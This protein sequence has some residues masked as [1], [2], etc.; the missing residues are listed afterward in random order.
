M[1]CV[2]GQDT[3]L[4][5]TLHGSSN[6]QVYKQVQANGYG[7]LNK[8][9]GMGVTRQDIHVTS[10][11]G[12]VAS[13]IIM[14]MSWCGNQDWLV[15]WATCLSP[16]GRHSITLTCQSLTKNLAVTLSKGYGLGYMKVKVYVSFLSLGGRMERAI[17]NHKGIVSLK[18]HL[19]NGLC[20]FHWTTNLTSST[21]SILLCNFVILAT[22]E[23]KMNVEN[24]AI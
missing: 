6:T 9:L 22:K 24:N 19:K 3:T 7:N 5:F 15:V 12:G 1:C 23:C 4:Y 16:E 11:Q 2:V 17:T 14:V 13:A 10:N 21:F 20:H 8:M 18:V